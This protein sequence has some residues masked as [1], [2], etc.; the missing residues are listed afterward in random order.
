MTV[1]SGSLVGERYRLGDLLGRGGMAD[2]YRAVDER[3]G[4]AVAVKV[5][6]LQADAGPDRARFSGEAR[7]LARLGHPSIVT[8][9]DAGLEDAHPWIAMELVEGTTLGHWFGR[10]PLRAAEVATVGQQVA[11]ALAYAHAEGV[12][13]RDVKPGNILLAGDQ[14]VLLADFGIAHVLDGAT[15]H[16]A[17]GQSVGSPAW[18]AP[19]QAAAEPVSSATDVYSLGLVLLEALSGE[20]AF[21]GTPTELVHARLAA[22]PVVPSSVPP[23]WA[24]LLASMT[25]LAPADR[26]A[27][28][29]VAARLAAFDGADLPPDPDATAPFAATRVLPAV[30]V[31][32]AAAAGSALLAALATVPRRLLIA[33]AVALAL[34]LVLVLWLA[35]RGDPAPV[36]PHVSPSTSVTVKASPTPT[37]TAVATP[38]PTKQPVHSTKKPHG[39]HGAKDKGGKRKK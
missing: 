3:L 12:V 17:V 15:R 2:V 10:G 38:P 20:R 8:L 28:A 9:L 39:K 7:T 31:A 32:G 34:L 23:G 19:E 26:P 30:R 36:T 22:P 6:R 21:S 29:E 16:T 13:H 35:L 37:H 25:A 27:A 11:E 33:A 5:L 14:R 24:A 4:R 1:G 18:L